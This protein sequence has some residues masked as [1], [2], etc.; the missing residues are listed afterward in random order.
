MS[1]VVALFDPTPAE[2]SLLASAGM[3][4]PF[5]DA[6]DLAGAEYAVVF[7]FA[8]VPADVWRETPRLRAILSLPA[9]ADHIPFDSLP[10]GVPVYSM[11][12]PNAAALAEHAFALLLA[13]AKHVV[14]HDEALRAGRFEQ[15]RLSKR[16]HGQRLLV[17]GAGPIGTRVLRAG[18]GF[19][20]RTEVLR[21]S[22]TPH[23]DAART[24]RPDALHEAL[25][26]ADFVV[27]ALPLTKKTKHVMDAS[28]LA[29]MRPDAVLVN[30]ARGRIVERAAL[31]RHL[32]AHPQFV[33]ATDVWWRYPKD[34][35]RFEESLVARQN[36]IG[37]P[38]AG[39][40]VPGWREEMVA[41]AARALADLAAGEEPQAR[42]ED[43]AARP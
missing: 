26:Q 17:L 9:G 35:D 29:A 16:L 3:G 34:D 14:S 19:G 2:L 40:M 28:A 24:H 6:R 39:A 27:L 5:T 10:Q 30:V 1:R 37:T 43:P 7:S 11:H 13:A 31:A 4:K 32:D 12:G 38:H 25:A 20:M 15:T 23:P 18:N 42:R 22:G 36:V 33:Y 21:A 8:D 41:A